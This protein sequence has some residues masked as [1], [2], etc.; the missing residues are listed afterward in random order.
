[1]TATATCGMAAIAIATA[2]VTAVEPSRA[3]RRAWLKA[4]H[5]PCRAEVP[6]PSRLV[7]VAV[8]DAW[9]RETPTRRPTM[10]GESRAFNFAQAMSPKML[11]G[12]LCDKLSDGSRVGRLSVN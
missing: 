11:S 2:T 9:V 12:F 5:E 8:H 3:G 4:N 7:A 1:M 6:E 10:A